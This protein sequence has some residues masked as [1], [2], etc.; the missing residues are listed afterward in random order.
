MNF[1]VEKLA[2]YHIRKWHAATPARKSKDKNGNQQYHEADNSE[3]SLRK[4]KITANRY[5]NILKQF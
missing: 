3:D 2:T 5:L 4:R 1:R